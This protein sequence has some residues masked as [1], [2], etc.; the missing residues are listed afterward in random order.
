MQPTPFTMYTLLMNCLLNAKLPKCYL[1]A[2]RQPRSA[3]ERLSA[4]ALVIIITPLWFN[5][6]VS[7]WLTHLSGRIRTVWSEGLPVIRCNLTD[8][9]RAYVKLYLEL[10]IHLPHAG[11]L[12][13]FLHFWQQVISRPSVRCVCALPPHCKQKLATCSLDRQWNNLC[14]LLQKSF[15]NTNVCDCNVCHQLLSYLYPDNRMRYIF[16]I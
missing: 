12:R 10:F 3:L 5:E 2:H 1:I 4:N 16:R 14:K 9:Q 7:L 11:P 6:L 8:P 15:R 13:A